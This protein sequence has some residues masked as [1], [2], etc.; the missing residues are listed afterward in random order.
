MAYVNGK[1]VPVKIKYLAKGIKLQDSVSTIAGIDISGTQLLDTAI[2]GF[3][4]TATITNGYI[5]FEPT[6]KNQLVI[7][8]DGIEQ[9]SLSA[10]GDFSF[11]CDVQ[12]NADTTIVDSIQTELAEFEIGPIMIGPVPMFIDLSFDAGIVVSLDASGS[13]TTGGKGNASLEFGADYDQYNTPQWTPIWNHSASFTADPVSLSL[14]G[15]ENAKVY[16]SPK[17]ATKIADLV[18]PYFEAPVYLD[19]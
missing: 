13:I 10:V 16:L 7:G 3:P 9:F 12:L 4:V 17:I 5:D 15:D 6:I 18:G 8:S 11:G 14:K 19:Y 1:A 2:A